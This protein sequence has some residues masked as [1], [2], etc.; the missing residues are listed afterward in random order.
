MNFQ[1]VAIILLVILYPVGFRMARIG[2]PSRKE[3]LAG[4]LVLLLF[5]AS[6]IYLAISSWQLLLIMLGSGILLI[7]GTAI[8]SNAREMSQK[9][10][11]FPE[12]YAYLRGRV[13]GT[14]FLSLI[15][16]GGGIYLFILSIIRCL[17]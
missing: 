15:F 9:A 16:F 6:F 7:I 2:E 11:D 13:K 10:T 3:M 14:I 8:M 12:D 1:L 17:G 5:L 4:L